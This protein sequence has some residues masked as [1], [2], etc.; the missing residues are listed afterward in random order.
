MGIPKIIHQVWLQ[1]KDRIPEKYRS[2]RESW[3]INHERWTHMLWDDDSIQELLLRR[4]P[5]FI[6]TYLNYRHLVQKVDSA[7]YFI[8]YEYGGFSIDIDMKS[9]KPLDELLALYPEANMIIS[10][11]PFTAA[12]S[13]F[14]KPIFNT[15]I[16][17]T[18]AVVGTQK[19][20]YV[21]ED[22]L[23][24]LPEIKNKL[25]FSKL[26]N[27]IAST[28]PGFFSNTIEKNMQTD[29][30]IVALDERYFES[31]F[32][33]DKNRVFSEDAFAE[34]HQAASWHSG[35]FKF[36]FNQYFAVKNLLKRK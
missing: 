5:W 12:E 4:F 21:W 19:H 26:L 34:H 10:K 14:L 20:Y 27:V 1:G 2:F 29:S 17:Y 6:T 28:G 36:I 18:N 13:S 11:L 30:T 24:V 8:L 3:L 35:I 23:P 31:G 25:A 33:F 32:S 16:F 15:D 9:C 22:V 7:R